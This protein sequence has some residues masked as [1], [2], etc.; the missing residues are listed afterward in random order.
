MAEE[1]TVQKQSVIEQNRDLWEAFK[2]L[3]LSD[4]RIISGGMGLP[5]S[6]PSPE[7]LESLFGT[8]I[9]EAQRRSSFSNLV[10][11]IR[12][13]VPQT[14]DK[15][16]VGE[17]LTESPLY[18]SV[19][20]AIRPKEVDAPVPDSQRETQYE[21]GMVM[22]LQCHGCWRIIDLYDL[23]NTRSVAEETGAITY[24][25]PANGCKFGDLSEVIKTLFANSNT[26]N[27]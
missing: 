6:D 15:I 7:M 2:Q 10:Q 13:R 11:Q 14:D 5:T 4:V 17:K 25:C 18:T 22:S 21:V 19:V 3:S 8:L 20:E 27:T 23:R 9:D 1:E 12:S 16:T 24:S 26:E